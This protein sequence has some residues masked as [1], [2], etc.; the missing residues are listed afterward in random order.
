MEY[1]LTLVFDTPGLRLVTTRGKPWWAVSND[2]I[3]KPRFFRLLVHCARL[4]DSLADC[5]AGNN[6][7]ISI[8]MME[9]VTRSSI[10]VI[11][12]RYAESFFEIVIESFSVRILLKV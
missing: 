1:G 11:P 8:E 4:A 10:R 6:S 12:R 5:T 7:A 2:D 9:I 3:A